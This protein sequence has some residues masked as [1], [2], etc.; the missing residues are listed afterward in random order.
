MNKLK[1]LNLHS[2]LWVLWDG[3]ISLPDQ[4]FHISSTTWA[5]SSSV[6][7]FEI[8][9]QFPKIGGTLNSCWLPLALYNCKN[10]LE[11]GAPIS[12]YILLFLTYIPKEKYFWSIQSLFATSSCIPFQACNLLLVS[13]ISFMFLLSC[14]RCLFHVHVLMLYN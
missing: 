2:I 11:I 3:W 7:A 6:Y 14:I 12:P 1:H 8:W 10:I 9:V 5:N 4:L 13:G